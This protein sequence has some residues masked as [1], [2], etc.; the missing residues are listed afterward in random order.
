MD[1]EHPYLEESS[2]ESAKTQAVAEQSSPRLSVQHLL[3]W[4]GLIAV[5][6]AIER[7]VWERPNEIPSFNAWQFQSSVIH[8]AG[9][10][11][12]ILWWRRYSQDIAFP[13]EPGEWML[14]VIGI[15]YVLSPMIN[16]IAAVNF[17]GD[18]RSELLASSLLYTTPMLLPIFRSR[19]HLLIIFYVV[20]IALYLGKCAFLLLVGIENP[21]YIQMYWIWLLTAL[22]LLAWIIW[23][24]SCH[25]RQRSWLHWLG[26]AATAAPLFIHLRSLA[27]ATLAAFFRY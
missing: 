16:H 3:V 12:L 27:A 4:V 13:T 18:P 15:E 5:C 2:P 26:M 20:Q 17:E 14:V 23:Q 22:A 8:A 7:R 24:D 21:L 1:D 9:I 11:A 6:F 25:E 19:D 10:G